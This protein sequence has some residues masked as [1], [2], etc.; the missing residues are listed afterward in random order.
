MGR[1]A[2]RCEQRGLGDVL[3]SRLLGGYDGAG[4]WDVVL[5]NIGDGAEQQLVEIHEGLHH[6]LQATCG[7]GLVSAFSAMLADRGYRRLALRELFDALVFGCQATHEVFATFVSSSVVGLPTAR[8]LLAGNEEYLGHLERALGLVALP[9]VSSRFR[10]TATAA[11]LRCC[12][13]PASMLDLVG[14][15]FP[16]LVATFTEGGN[17]PDDLLTAFEATGG[18]G[19]WAVVVDEL[20]ERYPDQGFRQPR[21]QGHYSEVLGPRGGPPADRD[22]RDAMRAFEEDVVL[23]RCYEHVA[24][25]LAAAGRPAV[26]WEDLPHLAQ[27]LT[28][29]VEAVDE[30]LAATLRVVTERRP[31]EDD[32][33]DFD[34]QRVVLREPLRA[35]V[36]DLTE[37]EP[38]PMSLESFAGHDPDGDPYVLAV[39]LKREVLAKQL[40]LDTAGLPDTVAAVLAHATDA[41][42]PLVVL[43]LLPSSI[44]PRR[45]QQLLGDTPLVVMT[46]HLTLVDDEVRRVLGTVEPVFVLMDLPVAWHVED[47]IRQGATVRLALLPL[48]GL[49][50]RTLLMASFA[51]SPAPNLRFLSIGGETAVSLL[52][53]RLRQKHGGA[54][55][56]T[57]QFVK[58]DLG[59]YNLVLTEVM[60]S[61]HVLD[62]D[63]ER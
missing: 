22:L 45:C 38:G 1:V 30:G 51:I 34:R 29:M 63:A 33:L 32:G 48:E 46:S 31:I 59:A 10:D 15:G 6:E 47:W 20:H 8:R 24:S 13:A 21:S 2:F 25:V 18:P 61:W 37:V 41:A 9:G 5:A 44:T 56:I 43:A 60:S 11:V 36:V 54:L 35:E 23:R 55:E 49:G 12:M 28:E 39:W 7:I 52:V 53:E 26:E 58:E 14:V 50:S 27:R 16:S 4:R 17:Q 19:S 40:A 62:Q 3:R 57:G 42:G